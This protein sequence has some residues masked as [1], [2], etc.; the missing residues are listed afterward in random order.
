VARKAAW[1]GPMLS[2][3]AAIKITNSTVRTRAGDHRGVENGRTMPSYR[4]L[5]GRPEAAPTCC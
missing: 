1:T 5:A 2:T 3:V 4:R